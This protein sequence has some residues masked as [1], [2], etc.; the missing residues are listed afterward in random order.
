VV[1]VGVQ[2]V[3]TGIGRSQQPLTLHPHTR[4]PQPQPHPERTQADG[5]FVAGRKLEY[6][7][8]CRQL[9]APEPPA[10]L[11]VAQ[12]HPDMGIWRDHKG[13]WHLV[14]QDILRLANDAVYTAPRLTAPQ[15]AEVAGGGGGGGAMEGVEAAILGPL[16]AAAAE[17]GFQGDPFGDRRSGVDFA[18]HLQRAVGILDPRAIER[19][20]ALQPWELEL[21][22]DGAEALRWHYGATAPPQQQQQ[23][24]FGAAGQEGSA[25]PL[26]LAATQVVPWQVGDG[27]AAAAGK[28][29]D[30]RSQACAAVLLSEHQSGLCEV[31]P[32]A[33]HKLQEQQRLEYERAAAA[34]AAQE[35]AEMQEAALEEAAPPQPPPQ[36]PPP[37][38]PE[39]GSWLPAK[40]AQ[41]ALRSGGSQSYIAGDVAWVSLGE[42]RGRT[43]AG[44]LPWGVTVQ[45]KEDGLMLPLTRVRGG[46]GCALGWFGL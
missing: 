43:A 25:A 6:L 8:F 1:W 4:P 3:H 19:G 37:S 44:R 39:S 9:P 33:F 23:Q 2:G 45:R 10:G 41:Q 22:P 46:F 18:I 21:L 28:P 30:P 27:E 38:D 31:P 34:A 11:Q 40:Q 16:R 14:R 7:A 35:D 17:A 13:D 24:Q 36:P 20:W 5:R 32:F 26:L 15:L 42:L 12:W 29:L